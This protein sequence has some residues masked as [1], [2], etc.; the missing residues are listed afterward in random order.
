MWQFPWVAPQGAHLP[1][2]GASPWLQMFRNAAAFA[3]Q[4][5]QK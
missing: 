1:K 3:E 2:D 5:A 4:T